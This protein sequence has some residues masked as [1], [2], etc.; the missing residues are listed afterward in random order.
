MR[1][2][3]ALLLVSCCVLPLWVHAV[4]TTTLTLHYLRQ[5]EV[6]PP[7]L[8]NLD[9]IPKDQGVVGAQL[10]ITDNNTTGRFIKQRF[11]LKVHEFDADTDAVQVLEAIRQIPDGILLLDLPAATL[12]QVVD[13]DLAVPRLLF[14]VS[15]A[16]DRFRT[17]LCR[18]NLLHT[19]PSRA[20]T[21]DALTQYLV[22]KR[23]NRWQLIE[24]PLA[25]DREYADALR[26]SAR[27][28]GAKLVVEKR[29]DGARDARRTAQAEVPRLTQGDDYDVLMVADVWGD[30]GEYLMYRTFDP[31]P[32]AG[33]QG[34]FAVGWYPTIEQWGAAQL[35][36]RFLKAHKRGMGERDYAAWV[37]VR[38][39]GEAAT[40][41][42][43]LDSQ[44]LGDYIQSEAFEIAA[45]KGRKLSYRA[46]SGQLRQPIAVTAARSLV[47]Q[48]PQEGYLHPQTELDTLG[49]DR[50]EVN[51]KRS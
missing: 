23:W 38:S 40:R 37:A 17:T 5:P 48:S 50:P 4:D 45:Y 20:M 24:G 2:W 13:A 39:V 11:E 29:W 7:V 1:R 16:D 34:L 43:S 36:S 10:G 47:T 31:R 21:T 8:S 9:A 28:F 26:R 42:R 22:K 46:W 6:R 27:K 12:E 19:L 18:P 3:L 41:T 33:T 25:V 35:Q 15:V 30:F 14:N 51:C 44:T 49:Y 32:V